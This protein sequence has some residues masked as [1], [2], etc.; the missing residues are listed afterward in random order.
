[1]GRDNSTDVLEGFAVERRLGRGVSSVDLVRHVRTG[2]RYA[3]KHVR[4]RT[5][6]ASALALQEAQRWVGLPE[7]PY[8]TA[9]HFT[10]FGGRHLAIFGEYV[11]GGS[12][13]DRLALR[14][15]PPDDE[16][17]ALNGMLTIAAQTAWALD[18]AHVSGTLH[19]DVKPS[20]ILLTEDGTAK[21]TDFGVSAHAWSRAEVQDRQLKAWLEETAGPL[22]TTTETFAA[23]R[24]NA[25]RSL[26]LVSVEEDPV[27]GRRS[28]PYSS[29]EQAEGRA[30]DEATDVWSWA[31]TL[32]EMMV[33]EQTWQSGTV[34]PYVLQAAARGPLRPQSLRFP[35][36]L[37]ELLDAC[38]Q[39]EPSRRP[40]SLPEL[41]DRVLEIAA[42][43]TG[44]PPA[45]VPP[46]R[47]E[48]E[49]VD[50]RLEDR[51][52]P[53]GGIWRSGHALLSLASEL[54]G[55]P[56]ARTAPF[57]PSDVGGMKSRLLQELNAV[58]E[59][60]RM[61]AEE[62]GPATPERT[63]VM[64][65]ALLSA[66][67]ILDRLGD[68]TGATQRYRANVELMGE[69][70]SVDLAEAL[71]A[72]ANHLYNTGDTEETAR[73][74]ERALAVARQL[75]ASAESTE[76]LATALNTRARGITDP[77][78][79]LELFQEAAE[80]AVA[81]GHRAGAAMTFLNTALV[82][83][84]L[85][86]DE[87]ARDCLRQVEEWLDDPEP[88]AGLDRARQA[89]MWLMLAENYVTDSALALRRAA[90]AHGILEELVAHGRGDLLG[91]LGHA[92]FFTAKMYEREGTLRG[93]AD[94]YRKARECLETA[95]REDG[96]AALVHDL[97]EACDH[98]AA[99]L[100]DDSP[101]EAMEAS[102]AGL[103]RWV[104]LVA[105]EGVARWGPALAETYR[106]TGVV[107]LK[108]RQHGAAEDH[109]AKGLEVTRHPEFPDSSPGRL[110]TAGLLR[111]W[112]ILHRRRGER[113]A[114]RRRCEQALGLLD[115]AGN[116]D[117]AQLRLLTRY[118]LTGLLF[119]ERRPEEVLRMEKVTLAEIEAAVARGALREEHL[120][121]GVH[122]VAEGA[123]DW[124][125]FALAVECGETALRIYRRLAE[126]GR[127]SGLY[128]ATGRVATQLGTDL[129]RLGRLPEAERV[130]T[131]ALRCLGIAERA[132]EAGSDLHRASGVPRSAMAAL[133]F[134][135]LPLVEA[136]LRMTSAD[137]D[138]CMDH[139]SQRVAQA[140]ITARTQGHGSGAW[141]ELAQC[142]G[143]LG[144]LEKS[145]DDTSVRALLS[146][147]GFL[148]GTQASR[149]N[150]PSAAEHGFR[151]AVDGWRI[152]AG[153][154]PD[155]MGAEYVEKWFVALLHLLTT[156]VGRG[157]TGAAER[158]RSE[159]ASAVRDVRPEQ[160]EQWSRLAADVWSTASAERGPADEAGHVPG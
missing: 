18:A 6:A 46:P 31:V 76:L 1:M 159:L 32:L 69:T 157:H 89:E 140:V 128:D 154:H 33:G 150:R 75:P 125:E 73:V 58:N 99:V 72:L 123:G 71:T 50:F 93:A 147:T 151:T 24:E 95:V 136:L 146:D 121:E 54:T 139:L 86:R 144:W 13:A 19:L 63:E 55:L 142:V 107:H 120:A 34:A 56:F 158:T 131:E 94:A 10:R 115:E 98:M 156:Q 48:P 39:A 77:E 68:S 88:I 155:G 66:A 130:F 8:I 74:G 118:T 78:V 14:T 92:H 83:R 47:P 138:G 16:A 3:V 134:R 143:L 109:Y 59:A 160:E 91:L 148:L 124:G 22:D 57:W 62:D 40:G 85:G 44:T 20:N 122:R 28:L 23:M 65:Q 51:R 5:A 80:E 129:V 42:R 145:L 25:R 119:D 7:H 11:T 36:E 37:T 97:A 35:R 133:V 149:E 106:K 110:A 4:T 9:C 102:E 112:A 116:H 43:A 117:H 135:Q 103:A 152:M 61:L 15:A 38:F 90:K 82:L 60:H 127:G 113:D 104:Q 21:L 132:G 52:M 100:W 87:A 45:L 49:A 53:H 111:E 67:R 2:E 84:D 81:A 70:P 105:L 96:R 30:L 29:P 108:T 17:E 114:A 101:Q 79:R 137:L 27:P 12:L 141:Q 153:A 126:E 41:A 26:G 64:G